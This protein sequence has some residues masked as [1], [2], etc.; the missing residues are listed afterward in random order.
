MADFADI[1]PI[2]GRLREPLRRALAGERAAWP[3]PLTPVETQSLIE[4]GVAPLVYAASGIRDFRDEAIRA[5]ALEQSRLDD[6]RAVLAALAE[7]GVTPLLMKGTPLAYDLY[8]APEL[9]PRGDTDLLIAWDQIDIVREAMTALGY[10][11]RTGSGDEHGVRQMAFVRNDH[12]YDI[13]WAITN[14]PVFADVLRYEDLVPR[15]VRVPRISEHARSLSRVDA[16]LLAC[17][18]RVAHHHDSERLIWLVDIA[19]LRDRMSRDEHRQFWQRAAGARVVGVCMRSIE[20]ADDWCARTPHNRAEAFLSDEEIRRDEPSRLFLDRD[21]TYGRM[22]LADLGALPWRA[23]MQRLWQLAFPPAR[24]MRES[25]GTR[26]P[27]ALPWLYVYRGA[28]GVARLF[29][30]P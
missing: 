4:H 22:M 11:E 18:H 26:N 20:L 15:A 8:A 21:L 10:A 17:I 13:H 29:R 6:L 25:F 9:R 12:A 23:R 16:L 3:E 28:R 14:T 2:T 30:R 1:L 24:F 5:A 7:R 19:L 27:L